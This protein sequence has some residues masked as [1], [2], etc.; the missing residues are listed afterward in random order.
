MKVFDSDIDV[1]NIHEYG[2]SIATGEIFLH[3]HIYP[4]LE[5]SVGDEPG[6]DFRMANMFI[7]NIRILDQQGTGNILIHQT[8]VGG[9]WNYGMAIYNAIKA[10]VS[11]IIILAYAHARSMSSLTLQAA[12]K[13]VLMPDCDFLI[14]HGEIAFD[15]RVTPVISEIEFLKRIVTPRM[16]Q[17]YAERCK[18]AEMWEGISR[19]EI[20]AFIM[21]KL[22]ER[23][24]WI[25]TAKEAVKFGFAD[26]I[27]GEPG[28]ETI[29]GLR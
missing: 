23:T 11:P 16:M 7:K 17:I 25:L 20:I 3:S 8:T 26:G 28:F 19:K 15:D 27:L 14:H 24:D 12:N 6:M 4:E 21:N 29:E 18:V 5:S 2:L 1:Y 9:D 22:R 10:C 13:R